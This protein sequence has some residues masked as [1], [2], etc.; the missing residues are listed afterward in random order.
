M[1]VKFSPMIILKW[2]QIK[3]QKLFIWVDN[4]CTRYKIPEY[5]RQTM[6]SHFHPLPGGNWGCQ[7]AVSLLRDSLGT[8]KQTYHK[9]MCEYMR[10]HTYASTHLHVFISIPNTST[11][12][13]FMHVFFPHLTMWLQDPLNVPWQYTEQV[14]SFK[15]LQNAPL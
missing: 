6:K 2:N 11:S 4:A 8:G 9:H 15:C 7:A 13:M 14:Y 3:L 10:A 12:C 1:E 5:K